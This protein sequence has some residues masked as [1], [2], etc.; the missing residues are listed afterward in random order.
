MEEDPSAPPPPFSEA[1]GAVSHG[2]VSGH[3][4]IQGMKEGEWFQMWEGT[5]KRGVTGRLKA[6]SVLMNPDG[7][8]PEA[9]MLDGY[10]A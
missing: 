9:S 4:R 5:I 2:A 1:N 7:P 10:R 8:T 3:A 6:R